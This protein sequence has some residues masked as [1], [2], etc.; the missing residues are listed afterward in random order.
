M[1]SGEIKSGIFIHTAD[2][3]YMQNAAFNYSCKVTNPNPPCY[4]N[5]NFIGINEHDANFLM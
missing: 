1:V 3:L 5:H 2:W 4:T